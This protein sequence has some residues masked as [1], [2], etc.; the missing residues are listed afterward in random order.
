MYNSTER[1]KVRMVGILP[2]DGMDNIPVDIKAS[3]ADLPVEPATGSADFPIDIKTITTDVPIVPGAGMADLPVDIQT[4][5]ANVPVGPMVACDDFPV[6]IQTVSADVGVKPGTAMD[7][8]RVYP[9]IPNGGTQVVSNASIDGATAVHYTVTAGKT[10]YLCT[11]NWSVRNQSG[12]V[13]TFWYRL[14]ND[15]AAPWYRFMNMVCLD[16]VGYSDH[17][18]FSPALEVPAAYYFSFNASAA[19]AIVHV[20]IF[21]YEI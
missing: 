16:D 3:T 4:V 19:G 7:S 6:D 8:L 14:F 18:T 13:A 1:N 5:S 21:G 17:T 9:R 12:G 20:S 15:S 2:S 11:V 10:L